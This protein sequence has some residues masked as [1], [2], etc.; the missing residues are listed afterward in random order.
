M[1]ILKKNFLFHHHHHHYE[2]NHNP[3]QIIISKFRLTTNLFELEQTIT[4]TSKFLIL[5]MM[6]NVSYFSHLFL[7]QFNMNIFFLNHYII[8]RKISPLFFFPKIVWWW[9]D[10]HPLVYRIQKKTTL[11]PEPTIFMLNH[12]NF[13]NEFLF[14]SFFSVSLYISYNCEKN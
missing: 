14:F 5:M 2:W 6:E 4:T 10:G 13:L 1:K 7:P 8:M 12:W 9:D 11:N 3:N